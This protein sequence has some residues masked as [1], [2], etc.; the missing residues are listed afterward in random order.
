[1]LLYTIA[2]LLRPLPASA[3]GPITVHIA[4]PGID[5]PI[6]LVR[7]YAQ[8]DLVVELME[9]SGLF[10]ATGDLPEP[11]PGRPGEELGPRYTLNWMNAGPPE[12][13]AADRT[14]VQSLYPFAARG[15]V[16]VTHK[17]PSGWGGDVV[18]WYRAH[19]DMAVTLRA[20]GA[21]LPLRVED[22][23]PTSSSTVPV[24]PLVSATAI[25]LGVLVGV[26]GLRERDS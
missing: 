20:L 12:V 18:G 22:I 5:H 17:T 4:G 9:Q 14:I 3:K 13:Q 10:Y 8:R 1:M 21:Q 15:P 19:P 6:E 2:L 23:R 26:V 24:W 16:L 11:L 7:N 25:M